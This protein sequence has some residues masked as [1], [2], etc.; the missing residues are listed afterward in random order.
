MYGHIKPRKSRTWF[1]EFGR[2]REL[3]DLWR[4]VAWLGPQ[5]RRAD[6]NDYN[7]GT[8]GVTLAERWNG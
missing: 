5:S 2:Y 7:N 6:R 3:G 4:A 1:L 8:A